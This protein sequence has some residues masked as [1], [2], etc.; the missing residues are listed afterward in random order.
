MGHV[1]LECLFGFHDW[2]NYSKWTSLT[3][4]DN[5]RICTMCE[6]EVHTGGWIYQYPQYRAFITYHIKR[7]LKSSV[8]VE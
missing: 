4:G 8:K 6:K 1:K 3:G 2:K 7:L 5:Y